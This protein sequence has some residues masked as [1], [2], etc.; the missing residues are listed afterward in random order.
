MSAAER[1]RAGTTWP[2]RRTI[3]LCATPR[4]GST[5]ACDVLTGTDHLGYPKEPFAAAAVPA[6]ADAWGVPTLDEDP[7]RYVRAAFTNGTSPNGICAVK[8]MWSD[9]P[10]LARAGDRHEADV[11]DCFVDPVALLVTRRDKLAAAISQHRAEQ[12][13]E[14]STSGLGSGPEPGPPDL[15]RVSELHDTQ[16]E[17]ADRWRELVLATA[18]PWAEVVYEEVAGEPA[19]I[20]AVAAELVGVE[21]G[22]EPEVETDLRVQRDGWNEEVRQAWMERTGGCDRGCPG[23]ARPTRDAGA[24]TG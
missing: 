6:C 18:V 22:A 7:Q 2:P 4:T 1:R 19:R 13:G 15:V 17:G 20:A 23:S 11:L 21:L 24:P 9:V 8:L 14:W 5:L 12:T 16:H 10:R 3:V